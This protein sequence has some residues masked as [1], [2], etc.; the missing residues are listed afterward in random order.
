VA[1]IESLSTFHSYFSANAVAEPSFDTKS[2]FFKRRKLKKR[3]EWENEKWKIL[4]KTFPAIFVFQG[5][6]PT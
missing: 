6:I 1:R 3:K 4:E 2:T 5:W